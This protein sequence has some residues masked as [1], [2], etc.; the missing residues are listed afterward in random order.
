VPALFASADATLATVAAP[1]FL[2]ELCVVTLGTLRIIFVSKGHKALAPLLGFFEVSLWLFAVGQTM[3]HLGEP[4]CCVAFAG[5][6]AV[7]NFLGILIEEKL[8]LGT[9][10]VRVI[11]HRDAGPLIEGLKAAGYGVT[12]IDA[13]GTTGPVWIVL[14]VVRRKERGDVLAIV[15]HHCGKAFYSVDDLQSAGE[16]VFLNSESGPG[17]RLLSV[18]LRPLRISG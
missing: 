11:T 10:V 5:G 12:R 16:G 8:A 18:L 2:A 9:S 13:H 6:F 7:G 17:W 3:R 4:L 1:N 15:R 14:T